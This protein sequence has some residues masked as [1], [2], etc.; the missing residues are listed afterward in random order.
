MK[1]EVVWACKVG[2]GGNT[3]GHWTDAEAG[4]GNTAGHW[5]AVGAEAAGGSVVGS[6]RLGM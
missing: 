1:G 6:H 5:T 2:A 3:A 4:G